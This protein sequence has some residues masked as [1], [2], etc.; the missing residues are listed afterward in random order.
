MSRIDMPPTDTGVNPPEGHDEKMAAKLEEGTNPNGDLLAGKFKDQDALV[1]GYKNAESKIGAQALEIK[2]LKEKL[3]E[4]GVTVEGVDA[5]GDP[6]PTV[7]DASDASDADAGADAADADAGAADAADAPVDL[8]AFEQSYLENGE[9]TAEDYASLEKAGYPK[10]TVDNYIAG[11]EAL[12]DN[13]RKEA[14]ESVGGEAEYEKVVEWAAEALNESEIEA[15]D[16]LLGSRDIN[17]VKTALTSL[18]T[19]Y[20]EAVGTHPSLVEG[21]SP[22]SKAGDGFASSAE[23]TAAMGD[24][25]YSKDPAYRKAVIE[26]VHRSTFL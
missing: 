4:A 22:A 11:Q 9:L 1:G 16:E 25:R 21:D 23:M 17:T 12:R 7:P 3:A 8:S 6:S 20:T 19:R 15:I 13:F 18:K 26:K 24:P 5:T 14:F 2:Q 10:E